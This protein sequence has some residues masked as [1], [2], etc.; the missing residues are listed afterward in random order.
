MR[1]FAI[2]GLC[3][4][5][6]V[7]TPGNDRFLLRKTCGNLA[8][9]FLFLRNNDVVLPAYYVSIYFAHLQLQCFVASIMRLWCVYGAAILRLYA[10]IMRL[11][12]FAFIKMRLYCVYTASIMRR[13]R[14]GTASIV[15]S[16]QIA[17]C[18][19]MQPIRVYIIFHAT[20]KK[21]A[22]RTPRPLAI[23]CHTK[24]KDPKPADVIR[25]VF[26]GTI[27]RFGE[28]PLHLYPAIHLLLQLLATVVTRDQ[29][30]GHVNS[31]TA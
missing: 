27:V 6:A 3:T 19:Q 15:Q 25:Y 4:I 14:V 9:H 10:A 23:S 2:C 16:P 30:Q 13:Q 18:C 21:L 28:P 17:N 26:S 7:S 8:W 5:D 24:G 31:A 1:Q 22:V 20:T 12:C 11:Y 29:S